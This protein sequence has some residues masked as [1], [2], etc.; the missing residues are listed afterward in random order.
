MRRREGGEIL[1]G[2]RVVHAAA[3]DDQRT[4]RRLR[5]ARTAA[6]S[7]RRD[8]VGDAGS[9]VR[10][11]RRNRPGSRTLR[12]ARLAVSRGRRAHTTQDR[13]WSRAPRAACAATAGAG[14]A[15]PVADHRTERVVD[16][17]RRL[18]ESLDL[19]QH[20]IRRAARERV[21]GQQQQREPVGHGDARSGDHVRR[22]RADGR[23]R[24]H[25]L[26]APHRLRVRDRGERHALFVLSAPRR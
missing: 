9:T 18:V 21:T 5:A 24:H 16:R 6:S 2:E 4:P 23:G 20:R 13:A 8:R 10:L 1:F 25:D 17:G 14:D 3:G 7:S 11:A 19:L 26:P 12:P 15:I 22:A